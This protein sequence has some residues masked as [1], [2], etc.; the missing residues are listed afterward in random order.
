M[1]LRDLIVDTDRGPGLLP[2]RHAIARCAT[3][4]WAATM[5]GDTDEELTEFLRLL[6]MQHV[7]ETHPRH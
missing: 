1:T 7:T 4:D 3:C 5:T 6:L 2:V